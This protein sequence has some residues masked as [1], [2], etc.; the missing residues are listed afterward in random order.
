MSWHA[1]HER[2][3]STIIEFATELEISLFANDL[4]RALALHGY[5]RK[6]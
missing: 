3:N 6:K 4:L 2:I 1:N 5:F